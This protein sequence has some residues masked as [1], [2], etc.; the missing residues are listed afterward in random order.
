MKAISVEPMS[1]SADGNTVTVQAT[2]VSNDTPSPL[3]TTGADVVGM[4]DNQVFA[5]FSL[6]YVVGDAD[7]KVYIANELGVF[8]PQ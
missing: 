4:S 6:L 2:I 1:V 5:P 8:I 3:P 7:V